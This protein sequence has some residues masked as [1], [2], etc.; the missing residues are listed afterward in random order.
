MTVARIL[1]RKGRGVTSVE[2][3]AT[4]RDVVDILAEQHI[5]ALIITD[6]SGALLGI[7]S[8]RD[9]V[10]A[11]AKAGPDSLEDAVSRHMTKDVVVAHEED[12]VL[13]IAHKMSKGRFRHMPVVK[14][15]RVVGMVSTGDAIKYRL[16]QMERDQEALREYIATA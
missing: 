10:R 14:D 6:V 12:G 5:G 4:L 1:A 11:I 15:G 9:V 16:E 13:E 2:P 7:V 3:H 8:E